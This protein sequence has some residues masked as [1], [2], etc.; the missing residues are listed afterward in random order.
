MHKTFQ[1]GFASNSILAHTFRH[2]VEMFI[3]RFIF[4]FKNCDQ[5]NGSSWAFDLCYL[6]LSWKLHIFRMTQKTIKSIHVGVIIVLISN[7]L[8]MKLYHSKT[9]R[10]SGHFTAALSHRRGT[11]FK[12]TFRSFTSKRPSPFT[13]GLLFIDSSFEL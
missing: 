5:S 4:T 3:N 12:Q 11:M 8:L 13:V 1:L 7:N 6:F 2:N 10:Y 9:Y